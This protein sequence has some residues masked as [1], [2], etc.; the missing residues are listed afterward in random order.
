MSWN[1]VQNHR[2]FTFQFITWLWSGRQSCIY[3]CQIESCQFDLLASE[4][5]YFFLLCKQYTRNMTNCYCIP[6]EKGSLQTLFTTIKNLVFSPNKK[7]F[8]EVSQKQQTILHT[9]LLAKCLKL[10]FTVYRNLVLF[11]YKNHTFSQDPFSMQNDSC[12]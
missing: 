9:R 12:F 6:F 3:L 2:F 4:N 7:R 11:D 5:F 1:V 8:L 10:M